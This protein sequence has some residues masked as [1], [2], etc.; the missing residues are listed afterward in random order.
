ILKENLVQA[1]ARMKQMVD[2]KRTEWEFQVGDWVFL[3]LQL[4]K[5]AIVAVRSNLKLSSK[6]YGP[7]QVLQ[8]IGAVAYKLQLPPQSNIHPVFHVSLN[9]GYN[10]VFPWLVLMVKSK[11]LL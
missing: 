3:K 7:F 8:R 6:C 2:R 5:Q 4:Y 9:N 10:R 11:L 1:Q